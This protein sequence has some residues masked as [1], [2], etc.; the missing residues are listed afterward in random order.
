MRKKS[1]RQ[2]LSKSEIKKEQ[3]SNLGLGDAVM[4]FNKPKF[5][6]GRKDIA[7]MSRV[8][9]INGSE[10]SSMSAIW[11][12]AKGEIHS[13][14]IWGIEGACKIIIKSVQVQKGKIVV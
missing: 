4:Y 2:R 6:T 13:D 5:P 3:E 8:A 7:V 1:L 11:K 9:F 14:V 12:D 10:W